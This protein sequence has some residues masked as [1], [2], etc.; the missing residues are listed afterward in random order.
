LFL[1]PFDIVC[2][3]PPRYLDPKENELKKVQKWIIAHEMCTHYGLIFQPIFFVYAY[4]VCGN[5]K[6]K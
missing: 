6:K 3:K 4:K 2:F 1:F 5:N